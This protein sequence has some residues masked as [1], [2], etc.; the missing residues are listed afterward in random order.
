MKID[1][2]NELYLSANFEQ[3]SLSD[4][5]VSGKEFEDCGFTGCNFSRTQ[6]YNCRFID[7]QFSGCNLSLA[8][9]E[10]CRFSDVNFENCKLLGV[11]WTQVYWPQLLFHAPIS[12]DRCMLNDGNF[13]GLKLDELRMTGCSAVNV[14]LRQASLK[15]AKF[16]AT[17]FRESLFNSTDLR[18]A[19]FSDAINYDIDIHHNPLKGAQ[20]SRGE[21]VR[22][23]EYL[24]ITL[25]D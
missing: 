11:D 19:D 5:T 4:A 25:T 22:L 20:F 8:Q 7:C 2:D 6:F 9:F 23:L 13:F 17:D 1:D 10:A 15:E 16:N 14:D 21:A 24:D 3:L 18:E 12:F